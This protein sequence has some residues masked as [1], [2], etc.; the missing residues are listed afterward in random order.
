MVRFLVLWLGLFGIWVP[1]YQVK[2]ISP[3]PGAGRVGRGDRGR[4]GRSSLPIT[5]GVLPAGVDDC[6]LAAL[7]LGPDRGRPWRVGGDR[8][9]LRILPRAG[10]GSP[11]V[12][13]F[14]IGHSEEGREILLIAVADEA[15]IRDLDKLKAATAALADPRV[16][17][18][19]A[20]EKI[21]A[22]ARP[23]YYLN[24]ALHS[25]ET[26]STEAMLELPTG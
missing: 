18:R 22:G 3:R 10:G 24:A 12:K 25:D 19:A 23:I 14:T 1:G 20:A 17:D 2:T 15:G 21:I 6:P 9:G 11:R 8:K 13:V 5:V 26:G 7:L 16:T 4:Y